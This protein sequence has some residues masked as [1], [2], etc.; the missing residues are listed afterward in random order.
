LTIILTFVLILGCKYTIEWR[1]ERWIRGVFSHYLH[2]ALVD[3]LCLSPETLRLGGE[4][5]E[6]TVLFADVRDFTTVSETL[7]ASELIELMN[8]FFTAMTDVVLTNRGM[9]DK[10][11]GDSLMAVFGAPLHD[12]QHAIRA[13]RSSIQMRAALAAL[14]SRWRSEGR[15]LLEMRI[16][17]NT[18]RMVI[19][20]VGTERRFDYTVMGDEVNVASRLEGANKT[21]GSNILI[22]AATAEAVGAR[23]ALT[24]RG[25]I[26]VK[27]RHQPVQVFELDSHIDEGEMGGG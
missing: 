3:E 25:S 15:P 23:F 4:E 26:H 6:L 22:S 14:H 5:R 12:A 21:V 24:P 7:T 16:G 8:E 20:N 19:G 18:G 2:P 9:L 11:I 27:G 17:I 10:Y 13:C 1:R